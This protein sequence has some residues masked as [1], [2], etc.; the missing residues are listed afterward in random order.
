MKSPQLPIY[1]TIASVNASIKTNNNNNPTKTI[2]LNKC[3]TKAKMRAPLKNIV[4]TDN[5]SNKNIINNK[6]NTKNKSDFNNIN[7]NHDY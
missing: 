4:L 5:N 2:V 6:N 7:N 3:N 1:S